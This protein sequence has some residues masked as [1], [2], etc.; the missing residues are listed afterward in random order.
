MLEMFLV[1]DDVIAA[2]ASSVAGKVLAGVF[3]VLLIWPLRFIGIRIISFIRSRVFFKPLISGIWHAYNTSLFENEPKVTSEEW[4][5]KTRLGK[6]IVVSNNK[7]TDHLKYIGAIYDRLDGGHMIIDFVRKRDGEHFTVRLVNQARTKPEANMLGL[8]VGRT[9][10]EN[11]VSGVVVVSRKPLSEE[12]V[13]AQVRQF[14][15]DPEAF[16]IRKPQT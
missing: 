6:P 14:S 13:M 8:W 4:N 9:Y 11:L 10:D 1:G 5:F 16:V 2:F 3:V 7:H 15:F 12:E